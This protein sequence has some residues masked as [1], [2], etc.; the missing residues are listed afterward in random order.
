MTG[1]LVQNVPVKGGNYK[2][3]SKFNKWCAETREQRTLILND[4]EVDNKI[5]HV[6]R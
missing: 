4:F 6:T 1:K 2:E 5:A 3:N